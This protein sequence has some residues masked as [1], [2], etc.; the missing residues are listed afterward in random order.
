[1]YDQLVSVSVAKN[2]MTHQSPNAQQPQDCVAQ[3]QCP[4]RP[5]PVPVLLLLLMVLGH[6]CCVLRDSRTLGKA[7]GGI[8]GS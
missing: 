1:M 5:W 8:N 4:A 3:Y 6:V 7:N 2:A